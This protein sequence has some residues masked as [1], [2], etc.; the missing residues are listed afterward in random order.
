MGRRSERST[1]TTEFTLFCVKLLLL[2]W[3]RIARIVSAAKGVHSVETARR[4]TAG[5]KHGRKILDHAV[6]IYLRPAHET[7][8]PYKPSLEPFLV[9]GPANR[10]DPASARTALDSRVRRNDKR[11]HETS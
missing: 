3:N 8:D 11:R 6:N 10:R 2:Q 1:P 4:S 9:E 5:I 7:S